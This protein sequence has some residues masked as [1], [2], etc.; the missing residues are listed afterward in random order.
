[1][2]HQSVRP[3]TTSRPCKGSGQ[4]LRTAEQREQDT[5]RHCEQL[6]QEKYRELA[7]PGELEGKT[8]ELAAHNTEVWRI[9]ANKVITG[10]R[11][12][13]AGWGEVLEGTVSVAVKRLFAA[14]V[15]PCNLERFHTELRLLAEVRH[16]PPQHG[17]V[18]WGSV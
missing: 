5:Q 9:P 4:Q 7:A 10:R 18:H 15:N 3:A 8:K 6:L 11:I 17:A 1:M 16:A 12:G 2:P 13:K 14:I